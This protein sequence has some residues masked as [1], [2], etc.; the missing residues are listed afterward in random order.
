MSIF[1]QRSWEINT[2]SLIQLVKEK[3][4]QGGNSKVLAKSHMG[5]NGNG[6]QRALDKLTQEEE[7]EV[8]V[9]ESHKSR[10]QGFRELTEAAGWVTQR[11]PSGRFPGRLRDSAA[12][13]DSGS[14]SR[15][16]CLT[17]LLFQKALQAKRE[18]G[19]F[20]VQKVKQAGFF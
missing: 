13:A 7:T 17:P 20:K 5:K 1:C 4:S 16:H 11:D 3:P 6:E 14:T 8:L 15:S 12:V 2:E 10:S 18:L 19:G 9:V